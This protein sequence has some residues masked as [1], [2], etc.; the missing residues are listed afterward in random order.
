[1]GSTFMGLETARRGL[2]AQQSAL[3]TTGNN[4][5]NAN[6]LGYTRQR[7]DLE[8]SQSFPGVGQNAPRI[9]GQLGTGVV[10]GSVNRIR[11]SFLDTQYRSESSKLGYWE[12]RSAALS[13][14]ETIM[15]EPSESGLST[16]MDSFWESLQDLATDP[17]NS[18]ARAVVRQRGIAVSETF[19]YLYKTVAAEKSDAKNELGVAEKAVNTILSQLDQVNKQ[20]GSVEP[21]GYL[22]N[23]LYDQR[24]SLLDELSSYANIKVSYEASG[25]HSLAQAEGKAIVTLVD[26]KGNSLGTLV[27]KNG[28]NTFKV[29]SNADDSAVKSITIGDN[30]ININDYE[31]T[32]KLKSIVEAYGY[33]DADGNKAGI[34]NDMLTELDNLAYTFATKFNEVH[35]QGMSPNEIKAGENQSISFFAD[36]ESADGSI[37]DRSGFASRISISASIENSLDNIANA[38]PGTDPT[39]ATLGDAT[40]VSKLADIINQSY[41]YGN[42][43]Q[44]S[45]FRNYYEGVI[46]SMAVSAQEAEKMSS[47]ATTLQQTVENK[48]MSTSA[49]SLDEEMTNMIQFQQAYNAAARMISL[50]DELLDTIINGMGVGGR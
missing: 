42:N 39:K 28:Y 6:T 16:S 13:N 50:T 24:D 11:D 43:S 20:I 3:Y 7:V 19:N 14:L 18:G 47:N 1:M 36:A 33:E 44:T 2:V 35:Q 30:E 21:N 41:D 45:N 37:T 8:Q 32:G 17:Q 4:I 49:V 31:S 9:A 22:P 25:G 15:N 34:Y 48:R 23:D 10:A 27:D 38:D 26:D 12:N 29:N 46:G 5:S 40:I